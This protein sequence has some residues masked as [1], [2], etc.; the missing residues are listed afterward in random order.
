MRYRVVGNASL[1]LLLFA[2]CA[3]LSGCGDGSPVLEPA[4][5]NKVSGD[6]ITGPCGQMPENRLKVRVL[7]ARI[8][9]LLGGKG[10]PHPLGGV[11]VRFEI[12]EAPKGALLEP[13]EVETDAG[14]VAATRVRLGDIPADHLIKAFLPDHLDVRPVF[15]R[16]ASGVELLGAA[17]E[18]W[19]G[20]ALENPVGVRLCDGAGKPLAGRLVTFHLVAGKKAR[21]SHELVYTDE[22]GVAVIDFTAGPEAGKYILEI[23]A[24]GL[25]GR[26]RPFQV[27][28]VAM[29]GW[30]A[31]LG[32]LGGLAVFIL[33]LRMMSDGLQRVAGNRLRAIVGFLTRNRLMGMLTGLGVTALIQSSSAT[34]V[35]LVGF[36]NAGL[37][38]FAQT[39]AV[40]IGANIGTTVT[41]QIISFKL[42]ALAFPAVAVGVVMEMLGRRKNVRFWGHVL[43]GFGLLFLGMGMMKSM[44]Q[45]IADSRTVHNLFAVIDCTPKAGGGMPV[46]AVLLG[47]AFGTLLTMVVQSSSATIGLLMALAGAGFVNYWSAIP[48]LLGDNIG[49]TVTAQLAALGANRAARR[50]AMAHTFVKVVGATYM[51]ILLYVFLG[52]RPVYLEIVDRL[53]IGDA[54]VGE[55]IER[56][57]ANAHTLFN[58][59]NAAVLLPFTGLV[60]AVV[61]KVIPLAAEEREDVSYLEPHLL[62]APSLA[63]R[64]VLNELVYM[65]QLGHKSIRDAYAAVHSGDLSVVD[66]LERRE[67]KIDR[68]Q[69]AI[70]DY[71]VQLSQL[72]LPVEVSRQLPHL[73]HANNDFERIGDHA[74]NFMELAE[75]KKEHSLTFSDEARRELDEYYEA[76]DQMFA[77]V[78]AALEEFDAETVAKAIK[79]EEY[80]N[81]TQKGLERAHF[82][83]LENGKCQPLAGVIFLDLVANIEKVG[84]HLTN[85]AEAAMSLAAAHGGMEE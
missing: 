49:T 13:A 56:H 68:R 7:S 50:T 76:M 26:Y 9:G 29:E 60:A 8:R 54:F 83:R 15:F 69:A 46:G 23:V 77:L 1:L 59:V 65:G 4:R 30:G 16:A 79:K 72:D 44:L 17:Q 14:G 37:M 78:L 53:T 42:G 19:A 71:V 5:I 51:T 21:L 85:I 61:E 18:A 6:D 81:A 12:I 63:I 24:T 70:S 57:I 82:E 38:R 35:M 45:T 73:L 3:A 39:I 43:I 32:V 58:I 34:T 80:L 31:L 48:I 28:I 25:G 55:N 41:A 33:G 20:A 66:D 62:D 27:E 75:R 11:R 67:E 52:G 84:D 10:N 40:D 2:N 36:V 64:Q 47:I 22:M 74:E